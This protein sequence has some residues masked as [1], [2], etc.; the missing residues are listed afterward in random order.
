[1]NRVCLRIFRNWIEEMGRDW[2]DCERN[3][4]FFFVSLFG[5]LKNIKFGLFYSLIFR[6]FNFL[7]RI[8]KFRL[9]Y[10]LN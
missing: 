10:L 8:T 4:F 1:M 5:D 7:V 9:K 2:K 6:K 3:F